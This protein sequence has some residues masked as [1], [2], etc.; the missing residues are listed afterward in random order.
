MEHRCA[1]WIAIFVHMIIF[2]KPESGSTTLLL[3]VM[4][5]HKRTPLKYS[6]TSKYLL[7]LNG[8]MQINDRLL[9]YINAS[10][11]YM[12]VFLSGFMIINLQSNEW[13][14]KKKALEIFSNCSHWTKFVKKCT[15]IACSRTEQYLSLKNL[16]IKYVTVNWKHFW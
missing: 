9:K 10:I 11:L 14:M 15:E 5:T 8:S 16:E 2:Y 7:I 6:I 12:N 3:K 4:I 1:L 13:N